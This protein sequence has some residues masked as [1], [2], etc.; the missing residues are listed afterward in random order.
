[1]TDN[2]R[3]GCGERALLQGQC[4]L[5]LISGL[6]GCSEVHSC[7]PSRMLPHTA[8]AAKVAALIGGTGVHPLVLSAGLCPQQ[9][10][11]H[12]A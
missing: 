5:S 1:M 8:S 7:T 11:H 12:A 2:G 10:T 6:D 3:A 9:C 4:L